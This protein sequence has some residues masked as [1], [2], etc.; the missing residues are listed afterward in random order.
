M[1][2]PDVLTAHYIAERWPRLFHMAEA[3][4]WPKIE[5]NGLLSTTAL[6]DR[7]GVSGAARE[8]VESARRAVAVPLTDTVLGEAWVRDNGPINATVLRRTLTGMSEAEWYRA[9]NRRVFFWLTQSRL[10][11]LRRARNYATREHD[12]LTVDTARLLDVHGNRVELA[13]LNSGAVHASA[14]YPR[15][16]GTFRT[17]ADYPWIERRRIAPSE[18][19]VELTV[20]YAVPDIAQ[21]VI[22]VVRR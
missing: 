14:D 6:L 4:A 11:R 20:P 3:G 2:A 18:P 19:I 5:Q 21:F 16:V 1:S 7:Y 10:E 8:A 9:L 12:I 15:G 13:H 17:I 22:D